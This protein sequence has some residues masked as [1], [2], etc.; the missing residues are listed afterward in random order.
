MSSEESKN[1]VYSAIAVAALV[2]SAAM[3]YK[4]TQLEKQVDQ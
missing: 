2:S 4:I 1:K 3:F